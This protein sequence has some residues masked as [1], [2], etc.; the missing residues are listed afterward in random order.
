[1]DSEDLRQRVALQG[2]IESKTSQL[3]G[4]KP[5]LQWVDL[6]ALLIFF[7]VEAAEDEVAGWHH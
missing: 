4:K 6:K 1:M 7:T 2:K 5:P 3:G